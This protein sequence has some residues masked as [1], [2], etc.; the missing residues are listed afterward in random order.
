MKILSWN[1][2]GLRSTIKNGFWGW[3]EKSGAEIVGLQEV[4]AQEDQLPQDLFTPR[5]YLTYFNSAQKKGYSGVA[6][7]TKKK[8]IRIDK[9]LGYKRF[10]SEGRMLE[11]EFSDF[12]LLLLYLP[13]GGRDKSNLDYKLECYEVLLKKLEKIKNEKVVILGDFN[14]AR[15]DVDLARPDENRD[16]I[17]FTPEER[18]Q[19]DK[20]INLGFIDSFR[21]FYQEGGHYTWWPY[22]LNA[23]ER[24][25][26]W[27]IDYVF[28]SRSLAS[29]IKDA[30]ILPDVSGSDHCPVG[31]E[32]VV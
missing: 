22:R 6:V 21:Q 13:H 5:D 28:V 8:P 1:V 20:I 19:M 7:F 23:K 27:R 10:D 9:I 2:N 31:I 15:E 29:R 11:M 16:N 17:M 12:T 3:L 24:N 4:K 25:L 30:F 32:I 14:I 26:G 18:K